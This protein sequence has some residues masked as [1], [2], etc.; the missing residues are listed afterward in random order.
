MDLGGFLRARKDVL[1]APPAE[2]TLVGGIVYWTGDNDVPLSRT[3]FLE[4]S[5]T[6]APNGRFVTSI[7]VDVSL[8]SFGV[9]GPTSD[10]VLLSTTEEHKELPYP[11]R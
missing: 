9:R 5:T 4:I 8:T 1:R 3:A 10:A 2:P 11:F 6:L 7:L